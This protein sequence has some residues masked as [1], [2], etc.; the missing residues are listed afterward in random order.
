MPLAQDGRLRLGDPV[1]A[2]LPSVPGGDRITLAGDG[3]VNL[4]LSC[5]STATVGPSS[6]TIPAGPS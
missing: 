1:S 5:A 3:H 2:Y 4:S 6:V